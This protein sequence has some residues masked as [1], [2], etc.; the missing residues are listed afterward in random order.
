MLGAVVGSIVNA[1]LAFLVLNGCGS[2]Y[3][4]FNPTD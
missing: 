2:L 3:L 4:N 1:L